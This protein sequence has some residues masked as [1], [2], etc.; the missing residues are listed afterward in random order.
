[1]VGD[2]HP[3]SDE[4]SQDRFRDLYYNELF[5]SVGKLYHAFRKR[6]GPV[7]FDA[8]KD[9]VSSQ[10][11][12]QV[13]K[14]VGK[15]FAA[16]KILSPGPNVWGQAD[17]LDTSMYNTQLNHN[18]HFLLVYIDVY[19]RFAA[20]AALTNKSAEKVLSGFKDIFEQLGKVSGLKGPAYPEKLVVDSGSEWLNK[21]FEG[22]CAEH[23]IKLIPANPQDK[24]TMGMV[25]RLNR[26]LREKINRYLTAFQT[27]EYMT[28]EGSEVKGDRLAQIMKSY[29]NSYHRSI[30]ANPIEVYTHKVGKAAVD[31]STEGEVAIGNIAVGTKVRKVINKKQFEKGSTPKWSKTVY[32]VAEV[33]PN[34]QFMVKGDSSPY[35]PRELQV[36]GR[37]EDIEEEQGQQE[38]NLEKARKT[39]KPL[40]NVIPVETK[41]DER[42]KRVRKPNVRLQALG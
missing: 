27:Q 20:V 36:V 30:K 14:P 12:S 2:T 31:T 3:M 13:H 40:G 38:A 16:R 18:V 11:A 21:T 42:L 26:T 39:E 22:F 25:E 7:S 34:G 24:H 8:V 5:Q 6:F 17:L 23:N 32:E 1:M 15:N 10:A 19:S 29:N 9:F 41:K 37:V 33:L 35:K 28:T 4:Q